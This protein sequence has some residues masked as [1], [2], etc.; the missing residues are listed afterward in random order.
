MTGSPA[1]GSTSCRTAEHFCAGRD[2]PID[3]CICT[4]DRSISDL[5]P[6]LDNCVRADINPVSDAGR[7]AINRLL[8]KRNGTIHRVVRVDLRTRGD[9]APITD[10]EL[11]PDP[12][13]MQPGPIQVF[14]PTLTSP[15]TSTLSYIV[16]PS[17]NPYAAALSVLSLRRSPTDTLRSNCCFLRT[18]RTR[19]YPRIP[20]SHT[21]VSVSDT[22]LS[23]L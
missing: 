12:S 19:R 9:R 11:S 7:G 13:K 18:V 16:V 14:R 17:P 4:Y 10:P 1:V 3:K 5:D 6:H 8:A 22:F 20:A 15:L 23:K 2:V 21:S